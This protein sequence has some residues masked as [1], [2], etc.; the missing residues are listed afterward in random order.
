MAWVCDE[1]GDYVKTKKRIKLAEGFPWF[2]SYDHRP[3][4]THLAIYTHADG[5]RGEKP[6]VLNIGKLG[7]WKRI[8]LYAEYVE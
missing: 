7:G 1:R 2:S 6:K 8:K 3:G 4:Y 5:G